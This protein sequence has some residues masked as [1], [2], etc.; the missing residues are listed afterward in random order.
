MSDITSVTQT[1]PAVQDTSVSQKPVESKPTESKPQPSVLDTVQI[2][3][4]AKGM[5]Q[6]AME[7]RAQTVQEASKGDMQAQRLQAREA[8]TAKLLA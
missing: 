5:M 3:T 1:P 2:S 8:A 6:E 4:S 7:S